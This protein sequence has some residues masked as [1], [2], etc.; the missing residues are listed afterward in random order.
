MSPIFG[1]PNISVPMVVVLFAALVLF[2]VLVPW[3]IQSV[4]VVVGLAYFLVRIITR[5]D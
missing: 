4:I 3:P 1:M 5:A 2:M